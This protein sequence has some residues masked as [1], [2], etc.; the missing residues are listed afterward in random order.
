MLIHVGHALLPY[1][2][3][4]F[5]KANNTVIL[6][7]NMLI[8]R[9]VS[10]DV[11]LAFL[12]FTRS[13]FIVFLFKVLCCHTYIHIWQWSLC[14]SCRWAI[15]E[16]WGTYLANIMHFNIPIAHF[17]MIWTTML[18]GYVSLVFFSIL[19]YYVDVYK[20]TKKLNDFMHCKSNC[21]SKRGF[22]FFYQHVY[23]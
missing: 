11:I 4:L 2:Y 3:T 22:F 17:S 14:S 20:T 10:W 12:L 13:W 1:F 7:V 5:R 18:N 6:F 21:L 9:C 16:H 8:A 15:F 19:F 23:K